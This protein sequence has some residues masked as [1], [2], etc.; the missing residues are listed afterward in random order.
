M[1][2][3]GGKTF[4]DLVARLAKDEKTRQGIYENNI[5]RSI[6]ETIV[7]NQGIYGDRKA[8]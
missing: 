4:D 7:G 2:L 6:T 5:Y 1:M 8:L 3:D